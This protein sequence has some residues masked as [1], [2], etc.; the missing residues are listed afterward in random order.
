MVRS[1]SPHSM[2]HSTLSSLNGAFHPLCSQWCVPPLCSQWYVPPLL[3]GWCVPPS[4]LWMLRSPPH[5]SEWY[6][7][8]P[9]EIERKQRQKKGEEGAEGEEYDD[10]DLTEEARR[11]QEQQ[12]NKVR[13]GPCPDAPVP[14]HTTCPTQATCNRPQRPERS[15]IKRTLHFKGREMH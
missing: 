13:S 11:S 7:P 14:A 3:P 5:L 8:V 4:P 2:A 10:G 12:L 1:P 6:V 9:S 15:G